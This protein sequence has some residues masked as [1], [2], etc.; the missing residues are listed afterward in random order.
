MSGIK[1][2]L[3]N[4]T[5]KVSNEQLI[6]YANHNLPATDAHDIE[7]NMLDDPFMADAMEGLQAM[8]SKEQISQSIAALNQQLQKTIA[9]KTKRKKKR[10]IPSNQWVLVA[11]GIVLVL[12]VLGYFVLRL[13]WTGR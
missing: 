9:A 2:I 11:I 7:K 13:Q 4:H 12:C 8:Q 5:A 1:D 6:D 3:S 10:G